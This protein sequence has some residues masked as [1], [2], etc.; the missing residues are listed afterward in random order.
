MAIPSIGS[1][2]NVNS[3]TLGNQ[4][5][6]SVTG[7]MDGRFAVVWV[8]TQTDTYRTRG[9]ATN[10][11]VFRQ[12]QNIGVD[13]VGSDNLGRAEIL[14]LVSGEIAV[15][16]TH[17]S[18]NAGDVFMRI[19]LNNGFSVQDINASVNTASGVA[20]AQGSPSLIQ[21]VT[22][23]YIIVSQISGT[24]EVFGRYIGTFFFDSYQQ[25]ISNDTGTLLEL[26]M[27]APLPGM[28]IGSQAVVYKVGA[29]NE[30]FFNA[31][32]SAFGATLLASGG[33][34]VHVKTLADGGFVTTWTESDGSGLKARIFN[35]DGSSRTGTIDVDVNGVE[36]HMVALRDGRILVVWS[37]ISFGPDSFDVNGRILNADGTFNTDQFTI[38]G[39]EGVQ[40]GPRVSELADGRVVIAYHSS[41]PA[42]TNWDIKARV[43]DPRE[44]AIFLGGSNL[45]DDLRG[46]AFNDTIGGGLGNDRLD[47][48]GG[49]D[50]VNGGAGIDTL[51][52]DAGNDIIDGGG[53]ADTID[54]GLDADIMRGG[55]GNDTYTVDVADDQV[56]ENANE[57][58]DTVIAPLNHTLGPNLEILALS[59][60]AV[61]GTGNG[62]D[63]ILVGNGLDNVLDGAAGA[64][65]MRGVTG[66]DSYRVE[67]AGDQII[68]N[69]SEGTD[70]VFTLRNLTL[71]ANTEILVLDGVAERGT[72][73]AL[74]NILFGNAQANFL[75]GAGGADTMVGRTGDDDYTVDNAGDLVIEN[76]NEGVDLV[77]AAINYMLGANVET[78]RLIGTAVSATGNDLSNAV[79]GNALDNIING[80]AHSDFLRGEGG[81]DTF[82]FN[83]VTG[84]DV[85]ADYIAGTD[86]LAFSTALFF[87]A[88]DVLNHAT[89]SGTDVDLTRDASH[90]ITLQNLTLATLQANQGDF[91][92]F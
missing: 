79:F 39:G 27:A 46:T 53:A 14:G 86:F 9:F 87:N 22:N 72:G 21:D 17:A 23:G 92:F 81:R 37:D 55:I 52:G 89:Q 51:F 70:T 35:S 34:N 25:S 60:T 66:N 16:Y 7:T 24:T 36:Q 30:L 54:G 62:L 13:S 47:G 63:N 48:A 77:N 57:G 28:G 73:N 64:D 32:Y 68:E 90:T 4:F 85:V 6:P 65:S 11:A 80:G 82:V 26:E 83:F 41:D 1:V 59:G 76:A 49:N 38:A 56:I 69:A 10:G 8:D 5:F 20:P 61:N 78:L 43:L 42:Q 29:T 40:G 88:N 50:I 91:V 84:N 19:L 15:A 71:A 33:S 12:E 45:N 3:T 74:D 18:S 2:I 58:T 31:F 75:D 67:D 44:A